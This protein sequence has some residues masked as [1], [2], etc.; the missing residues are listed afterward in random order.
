MK[1]SFSVSHVLVYYL[2]AVA[3]SMCF[4]VPRFNPEW[5][6][7]LGS[8]PYGW[9]LVSLLR[10]SGP[11]AGGILCLIIFRNKYRRTITVTGNSLVISAIYFLA[12]VL[13]ISIFGI[14]RT[15]MDNI[16]W[17]GLL[18]GFTLMVYC[19]FEET[20]WR[21]F[22]QDEMRG[23]PNPFR[24]IYIG[25]LWYLWHLN[26]ISPDIY[27]IKF[28][29]LV[30]LPSCIL[31]SWIIGYM[32]DKYKSILVAAAI[33]SIFNIFFDLQT[34]IKS[35]AMIVAGVFIIWIASSFSMERNALPQKK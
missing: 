14:S 17:S 15:G 34:D 3:L 23:I 18:S 12:P 35:K 11:L 19:L 20:G 2:I 13:M 7:T 31:G 32:A 27:S 16:H 33:H 26:F 9:I 1:K 24:F 6:V 21:G 5:Y 22:L 8:Y 30:H 25:T 4:R 10:A 29:L 28:G